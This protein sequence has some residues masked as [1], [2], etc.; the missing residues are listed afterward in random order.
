[1][2]RCPLGQGA[3]G[4]QA[5]PALTTTQTAVPGEMARLPENE[6]ASSRHK[7][8]S[9]TSRWGQPDRL[10]LDGDVCEAFDQ[11]GDT[12]ALF[13]LDGEVAHPL[14]HGVDVQQSV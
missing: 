8:G 10:D 12:V 5:G 11:R 14:A 6:P 9:Y 4:S 2:P 7:I 13:G 1:M 3:D